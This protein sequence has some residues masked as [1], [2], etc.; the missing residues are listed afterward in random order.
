[1]DFAM[2]ALYLLFL[3]VYVVLFAFHSGANY[4]TAQSFDASLRQVVQSGLILGAVFTFSNLVRFGAAFER[5]D[6]LA[7][8]LILAFGAGI[9]GIDRLARRY[10]ESRETP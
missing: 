2:I 3:A 7:Y 1:M 5:W 9:L 4:E 8:A 10:A 6:W